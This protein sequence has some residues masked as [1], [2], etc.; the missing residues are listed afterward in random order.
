MNRR[1]TISTLDAQY[2]CTFRPMKEGGY[3]VRCAAFPGLISEG[4]TLDAAR[5]N[6][7][8]ALELCIEVY[9]KKGWPLPASEDDPQHTVEEMIPVKL[10]RV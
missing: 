9:Q 10:A 8:E 2:V 3:A 7:R 6:A 1:E 4:D 5:R